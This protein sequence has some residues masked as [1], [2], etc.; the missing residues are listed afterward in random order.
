MV[1]R[2]VIQIWLDHKSLFAKTDNGLVASYDLSKFKG[3]QNATDEQL[4]HYVVLRG[5]D[6]YW[7]QL[8]EDINLEGMFYDNHLCPLTPTEDSV[9]YHPVPESG[10]FAAEP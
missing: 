2:K 10:D 3:F 5:K 4:S 8:D 6:V 1:M 9:V 7:P